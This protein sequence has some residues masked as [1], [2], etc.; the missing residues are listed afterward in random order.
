[1]LRPASQETCLEHNVHG[2]G[3]QMVSEDSC[4]MIVVPF[5][6]ANIPQE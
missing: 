3:V 1:M 2:R 4:D 6:P 5:A